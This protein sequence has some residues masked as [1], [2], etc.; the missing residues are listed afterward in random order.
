MVL[1]FPSTL[2]LFIAAAGLLLA[3]GCTT[4]GASGDLVEVTRRIERGVTPGQ[5]TLVFDSYN[6]DITLEG[7]TSREANLTFVKHA[8]AESREE[9]RALLD[10]IRIQERG[11]EKEFSY[12]LASNTS[13]Q[14]SVDVRGSVPAGTR[15]RVHLQNGEVALSG[16]EGPL[17]V[18]N[19]N[20]RVRIG[21]SGTATR[22]ET[23]N[24]A[25]ELGMHRLP[26]EA[27]VRLRSANGDLELTLPG[28]ASADVQARTNAGEITLG[29]LN[30]TAREL[31][32]E[33][34]GARFEGE[35]GAGDAEV[36]LRTENGNI[37]LR[38]GTVRRLP[39]MEAPPDT[40][41]A[42]RDSLS[43]PPADT[44]SR[45]AANQEGA[46]PPPGDAPGDASDPPALLK[47]P[48]PAPG[49][50]APG[51]GG[52]VPQSDTTPSR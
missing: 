18:N 13:G 10:D 52:P 46:L 40:S 37:T 28:T 33:G 31:N 17:E 34:A 41:G 24:G 6:G 29:G 35:L 38:Q 26:P 47:R 12:Q 2:L 11:G 44:G 50:S 14:T 25:V 20:G 5:R 19:E 30:F 48:R 42:A 8:R 21:G 23:S 27:E 3:S 4:D 7:T 49:T 22:A 9:A 39:G 51:P 43:A 16:L 45:D 1:R 36:R 15:L 32:Q